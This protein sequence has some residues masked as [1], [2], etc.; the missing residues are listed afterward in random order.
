[1]G[2]GKEEDSVVE[3]EMKGRMMG[4]LYL[5]FYYI[6]CIRIMALSLPAFFPSFFI[7]GS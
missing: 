5:Y 2:K 4:G 7:F 3:T 1:M 6:Y